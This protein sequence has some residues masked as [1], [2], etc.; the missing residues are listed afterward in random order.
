MWDIDPS[1]TA[2]NREGMLV[3]IALAIFVVVIY[4]VVRGVLIRRE[5]RYLEE[6]RRNSD[7]PSTDEPTP[8]TELGGD[9]EKNA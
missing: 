3:A 6:L 5:L 8:I 1:G 2:L 9:G 4:L 7:P